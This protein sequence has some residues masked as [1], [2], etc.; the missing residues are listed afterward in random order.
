[1]ATLKQQQQQQKSIYLG[2]AYWFR[3]LVHYHHSG[4]RGGMQAE[5]VL[6]TLRA[7]YTDPQ[8]A[9]RERERQGA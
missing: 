4:E 2:L 9:G 1:M 7:V 5:I 6:E 3:S 8:A